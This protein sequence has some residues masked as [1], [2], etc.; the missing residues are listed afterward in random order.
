[1]RRMHRPW[2]CEL[3][4]ASSVVLIVGCASR[5]KDV[6]CDGHLEAINKP[7]AVKVASAHQPESA[8]VAP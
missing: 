8:K 4:L 6:K 7:V 5:G 2:V 3:M 1:M